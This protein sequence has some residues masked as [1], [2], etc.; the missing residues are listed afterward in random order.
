[1]IFGCCCCS[2]H[3][4]EFLVLLSHSQYIH[5][6]GLSIEMWRRRRKSAHFNELLK[7]I[8]YFLLNKFAI[9]II[10]VIKSELMTMA[11]TSIGLPN[12]WRT[13]V[14]LNQWKSTVSKISFVSPPAI[15]HHSHFAIGNRLRG[16][17]VMAN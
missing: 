13:C 15:S 9:T 1:M 5:I 12:G 8:E 6:D 4:F 7:A 10:S 17:N 3:I 11:W 16:E 14:N 2:F